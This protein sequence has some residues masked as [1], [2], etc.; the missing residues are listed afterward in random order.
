[1]LANKIAELED[2]RIHEDL[3]KYDNRQESDYIYRLKQR[4]VKIKE[5]LAIRK[6]SFVRAMTEEKV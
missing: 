6:K 2:Q 3:P 4:L 1:M 5:Y